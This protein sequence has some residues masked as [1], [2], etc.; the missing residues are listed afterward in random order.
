M[1]DKVRDLAEMGENLQKIFKRLQTNQN[2]LKLLYYTDKDNVF[3]YLPYQF[4][5]EFAP[6]FD[7]DTNFEGVCIVINR[8]IKTRLIKLIENNR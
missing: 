5:I 2:L 7:V 1:S 4:P 3:V 8:E 6:T